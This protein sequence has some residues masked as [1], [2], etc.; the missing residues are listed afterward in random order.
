MCDFGRQ[1][2]DDLDVREALRRHGW[3]GDVRDDRSDGGS[4][5]P[6][7]RQIAAAAGRQGVKDRNVRA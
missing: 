3:V 4:R 7:I 1:V 5:R 6:E 2:E